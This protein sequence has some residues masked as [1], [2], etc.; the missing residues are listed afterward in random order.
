MLPRFLA[1]Q[2]LCLLF[3]QQ[4]LP[5]VGLLLVLTAPVAVAQQVGRV[6]VT[7]TLR[8]AAGQP[9]EQVSVGVEGQPGGT[10][11]D[12]LGRFGLNVVRPLSGKSPVLVVRRLGYRTLR[13]PI[14]LSEQRELSLTLTEETS[15]LGNVTVRGR[16]D[17]GDT[18]EQVSIIHLDPRAAKE[19][20]SPF[21]DFNAILKTLPGVTSTNELTSTYSVRGGNYEENLV[22]VN[23]F[24]IYRPFL[25]TAAAQE[26]LSFIN[27]DLVNQIEF[28]SGG[29]QPKYGD[30]LSSVLSIDYKQPTKFGASVS[31]SL[32][33]GSVHVEA[34]SPNK[35]V[36]YLAG[37]RYK[38][39]T[40]V[41][42]SLEQQRG[43]YNP[44]FYD[45]QS[46]I[47]AALGPKENPNKTLLGLLTTFGHNDFR[48]S[49]ESGESTFSTDVNQYTRLTIL[50]QGRERMQYDT[51]QGGLNLRHNF[52]DNLQMELLAGMLYS[53]EFEYRDVEA[54]YSLAEINT[55]PNSPDYKKKNFERSLAT[56]FDHSRNNLTARIATLET[57]G[58][59]TPGQANTVRWGLKAGR[60]NIDD[61][62]NEYSFADSAGFVPDARRTRLRSELNLISTR[63]QG[64]VQHTY[65]FD[66]LRTLTYG[67]RVNYWTV[68]RQTTVSPRVQYSFISPRRPNV[69]WKAAAGVYVQP[70]FYRELR[71]Q[72]GAPQDQ[73][74]YIN[75]ELRA[76]RSLHFIVGNE[77]RFKQWGRPFRFT[78]EAYYKYLTDVVPYDIDNVRLRYF[79]KNNARAYA[80]GI[81]SRVS[82][83]FVKGVESWF[84]LGVL[85]T[86]ENVAGDSISTY[87]NQG[88]LL[89]REPKGYIRR[90]SDQR[91]NLG[92]FFQDN[93]PTN[94]SVKGYV[95]L[96]FGTGLPF[97]PPGVPDLRGT[98]RL[99]RSYKRVD[100]GFSKVVALR[101]TAEPTSGKAINLESLWLS[102]E[103]L[104]ILGADNVAGYSYL[105]DL[106][107]RTYAVPNFL[108][109]RVVNLRAIVRF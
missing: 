32:V 3:L 105:Q 30:K 72:I 56:R 5:A 67:A 38:N 83:E 88:G 109:Q 73:V 68:N 34:T 31:A 60:E 100:M 62:L 54:N 58:T 20:P 52:R 25:V 76:Q 8:N 84:S 95:N 69:S 49:P 71:T 40:Y 86:R 59:W 61:V 96:V 65:V 10:T 22:Y 26:G 77:V 103:I 15:A 106:N 98:S 37:I 50:Y 99:T 63:Y 28:S 91:V 82:G 104:N 47:K 48:F 85:T 44:T 45:G 107:G 17:A 93:L 66:S 18:R 21:G 9:L 27:P 101:T 79:A 108:S 89:A 64:Y 39:A 75:P 51:Y 102:L 87:D 35:R 94:P 6:L 90:P 46:Y 2:T 41:L 12:D 57:R 74:G 53:R 97:S 70:P 19:I 14:N 24:E 43:G 11:T 92:I 23:G 80:A 16:S 29:W 4:P 55:D 42:R 36:S 13:V 7:G 78:G 1:R 81:D 33:G